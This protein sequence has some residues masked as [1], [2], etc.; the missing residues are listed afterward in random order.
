[1]TKKTFYIGHIHPHRDWMRIIV[2]FSI[3]TLVITGWS[4]YLFNVSQTDIN[5]DIAPKVD[6][7]A[8]NSSNIDK[9]KSFFDDRSKTIAS[10]TE[11]R[12]VDPSI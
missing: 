8:K 3:L 7:T 5:T 9:V 6:T 2:I 10:S 1:M 4:L 12:F 11:K